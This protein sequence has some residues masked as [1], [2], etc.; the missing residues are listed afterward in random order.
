MTPVGYQ[1]PPPSATTTYLKILG[2]GIE[3]LRWAFTGNSD[4]QRNFR[5][6]LRLR[7]VF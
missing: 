5:L 4:T 1:P 7:G 2:G 6:R 3:T